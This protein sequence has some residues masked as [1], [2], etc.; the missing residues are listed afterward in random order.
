MAMKVTLG[1][2]PP[3][4]RALVAR[5]IEEGRH[6]NPPR[7]DDRLNAV[8]LGGGPGG[9]SY[10][11]AAG[12]VYIWDGWDDSV[13][14]V[15]DGLEKITIIVEATE[16]RPELMAWFPERPD[17]ALTCQQCAGDGWLPPPWPKVVCFK[18]SGLG[19][20]IFETPESADHASNHG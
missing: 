16:C 1:P 19:W 13:R 2:L 8:F 4:L 3:Q 14:K 17:Q 6:S 9:S 20:L 18:C 11:D 12:T 10:L 7:T 5:W 15:E